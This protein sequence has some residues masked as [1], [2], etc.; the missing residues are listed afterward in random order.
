MSEQQEEGFEEKARFEPFTRDDV[1]VEIRPFAYTDHASCTTVFTRGN[2]GEV[3]HA[4][5]HCHCLHNG[6]FEA[7]NGDKVRYLQAHKL[8]KV[9]TTYTDPVKACSH[10]TLPMEDTLRV[11]VH[12]DGVNAFELRVFERGD[13]RVHTTITRKDGEVTVSESTEVIQ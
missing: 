12:N 6:H 7:M 5:K 9:V 13:E 4:D 11:A 10:C 1:R 8:E 3:F 2:S